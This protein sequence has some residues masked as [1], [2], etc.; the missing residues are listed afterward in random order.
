MNLDVPAAIRN[1]DY[2]PACSWAH[3]AHGGTRRGLCSH[4]DYPK[5]HPIH[6]INCT[7]SVTC[8][9]NSGRVMIPRGVRAVRVANDET[10][11]T[12]TVLVQ[13]DRPRVRVS[14]R[15]ETAAFVI[16]LPNHA[17]RSVS[18]WFMVVNP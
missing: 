13:L 16:V 10:R 8:P 6:D 5:S 7:Q 18:A 3:H 11:S 4:C 12:S 15:V 9:G 2:C 17:K 14:V 1:G